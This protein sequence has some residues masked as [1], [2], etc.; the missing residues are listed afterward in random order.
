M[1]RRLLPAA[2]AQMDKP[3]SSLPDHEKAVY[4]LVVTND[5]KSVITPDG[6]AVKVWDL[7]TGKLRVSLAGHS[8]SVRALALSPDGKT[9]ASGDGFVGV[10]KMWD[11]VSQKAKATFEND[12][13]EWINALAF[14]PDGMSLATARHDGKVAVW[15]VKAGNVCATLTGL[16]PGTETRSLAIAPDGKTLFGGVWGAV[17]E[18]KEYF[19]VKGWDL[20]TGKEK[21]TW[22]GLD[23]WVWRLALSPDGKTLATADDKGVKLWDVTM[24][25]QVAAFDER[26]PQVIV[27]AFSPDG[28]TLAAGGFDGVIKLWDVAA[29]KERAAISAHA[30]PI[31]S[32]ACIFR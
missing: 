4:S 20:A 9:L 1:R 17:G 11:L 19:E 6:K 30:S 14:T 26:N 13:R 5:G 8:F 21:S 22:K 24:G 2:L 25:K 18:S 7:A 12:D 27:V 28:K 15:D 23:G 10:V 32:L 16:P 3:R 31:R 29:R